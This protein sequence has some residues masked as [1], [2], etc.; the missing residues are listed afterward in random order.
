MERRHPLPSSICSHPGLP[1]RLHTRV[2]ICLQG[3]HAS[4]AAIW[5]HRAHADVEAY[6]SHGAL[7]GMRKVGGE[8]GGKERRVGVGNREGGR[9]VRRAVCD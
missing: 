5:R 8:G 9:G 7:E 2:L 3:C 6:C 1:V 4:V